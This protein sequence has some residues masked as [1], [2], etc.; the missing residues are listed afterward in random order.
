MLRTSEVLTCSSD[1]LMTREDQAIQ[2]SRGAIVIMQI[3]GTFASCRLAS[4]LCPCDPGSSRREREVIKG[5][6]EDFI[7]STTK[8]GLS[9]LLERETRDDARERRYL[10]LIY[11]I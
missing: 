1:S 6:I 4:F 11:M 5:P 9:I 3:R 8:E 7:G 10:G 2:Q